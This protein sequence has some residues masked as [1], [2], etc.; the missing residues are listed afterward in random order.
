[1]LFKHLPDLCIKTIL[2]AHNW[3][4]LLGHKTLWVWGCK[5]RVVQDRLMDFVY[6]HMFITKFSSSSQ[7]YCYRSFGSVGKL[8]PLCSQ[9]HSCDLWCSQWCLHGNFRNGQI[10][11]KYSICFPWKSKFT[12]TLI[13]CW[14]QN[15]FVFEVE[16]ILCFFMDFKPLNPKC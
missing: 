12:I 11:W 6:F 15:H 13:M 3:L 16:I 10:M 4:E 14:N 8:L 5:Y 1:M 2:P 7:W 9:K